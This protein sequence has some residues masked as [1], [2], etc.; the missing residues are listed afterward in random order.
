MLGVGCSVVWMFGCLNVWL[1]GCLDVIWL[2]RYLFHVILL[3]F[4][5]T[6]IWLLFSCLIYIVKN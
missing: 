4:G 2:R 3:L 6:V 5:C 1:F